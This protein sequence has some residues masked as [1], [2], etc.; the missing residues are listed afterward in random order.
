M[1]TQSQSAENV[2]AVLDTMKIM[3]HPAVQKQYQHQL[4]RVGQRE[5]KQAQAQHDRNCNRRE[6]K[7]AAFVR[8]RGTAL[9]S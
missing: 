7:A 4:Q 8:A 3:S 1:N 2:M 6:Q 9:S 5:M